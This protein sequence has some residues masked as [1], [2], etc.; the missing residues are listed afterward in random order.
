MKAH[1]ATTAGG[2]SRRFRE[3]L[4]ILRRERA[5]RDLTPEKLTR[6]LTA[7][8]PT[9]VKIGQILSMRDDVLPREYT[10]HLRNL[11]SRVQPM[12]YADAVRVLRGELGEAR[13]SRLKDISE[14]PLGSASMAQAHRARLVGGGEVV[15]KVQRPDIDQVMAQDLRLLR[16]AARLLGP[17]TP[18]A[19]AVNLS[20]ALDEIERATEQELDFLAEAEHMRRLAQNLRADP[21]CACP[22]VYPDMTTRRVLTME[23][24]DGL[25]LGERGALA[26]AGYDP[27]E[28]GMKLAASFARQVLDDGFFHAD[29]HPGN[30]FVRGSQLVWMDMGM[31][32]E[33]PPRDRR[34]MRR[35]LLGVL[36]GDVGAV[37][38]ALLAMGEVR[39]PVAHSALFE[40]VDN[41]IARYAD[42]PLQDMDLSAVLTE[43]LDMA[44]RH[45]IA[46]PA[47]MSLL[48]RGL[49][50]VEGT[51]AELS[52]GINLLS[53]LR[54]QLSRE[55]PR[56]AREL[57]DEAGKAIEAA[58]Y[59]ARR[60]VYLPGQLA[61]LAELLIKGQ[62]KLNLELTGSE[63]PMRQLR[64]IVDRLAL[65]LLAAA[66]IVGAALS[67]NTPAG[68]L[69]FAIPA[70]LLC[71][72]WLAS[73]LRR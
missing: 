45:D 33:I 60:L 14:A 13:F 48:A 56:N 46:L 67:A 58:G 40:D 20:R 24:I 32:G 6:L 70:A 17:F 7:L 52:P 2:E 38:A 69:P 3:I 34:L 30:L 26:A 54:A 72:I 57:A 21:G 41:V 5:M 64:R 63:K 4:S 50:T 39:G 25:P 47:S 42:M 19:G 22:I 49:M 36:H 59:S 71:A 61:E 9:Y 11:Q 28:I 35:A 1:S 66:L 15:V 29:P 8:G 23:Y 55:G 51:L 27:N 31:M 44:R 37:K 43:L 16:R 68:P 73:S 53:V 65:A 10:E 18:V 62:A 12:P